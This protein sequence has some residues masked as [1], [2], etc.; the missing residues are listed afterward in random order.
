MALGLAKVEAAGTE[1]VQA[2]ASLGLEG[3]NEQ[4]AAVQQLAC[5]GLTESARNFSKEERPLLCSPEAGLTASG[6][7]AIGALS[8]RSSS[9]EREAATK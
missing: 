5:L 6:E 9:A 7:I 4:A 1:P 3:R 2:S 8:C